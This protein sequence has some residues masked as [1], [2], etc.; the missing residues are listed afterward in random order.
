M[1]EVPLYSDCL[2]TSAHA[3]GLAGSPSLLLSRL[4]LSDA[5]VYEP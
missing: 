1:S 3:V 5:Q 4:E 2:L